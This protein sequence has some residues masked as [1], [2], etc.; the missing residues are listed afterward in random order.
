MNDQNEEKEKRRQKS[1][2]RCLNTMSH[3][4]TISPP[5]SRKRSNIEKEAQTSSEESMKS[6][7]KSKWTSS[8]KSHKSA[9]SSRHMGDKFDVLFLVND[10]FRYPWISIGFVQHVD[11][12][13]KAT[14]SNLLTTS[15]HGCLRFKSD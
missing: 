8:S 2:S 11:L 14:T 5:K 12:R 3:D 7:K 1:N 9:K 10:R 13:T 15:Q 4:R 6:S